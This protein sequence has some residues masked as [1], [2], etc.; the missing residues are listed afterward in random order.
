MTT[1]GGFVTGLACGAA[2]G[3]VAALLFAPRQGAELRARMG[4]SMNQIGRRAKDLSDR[5]TEKM[6]GMAERASDAVHDTADRAA[7]IASR[8]N[9]MSGTPIRPS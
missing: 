9:D 5:T 6:S 3:G 2:L 4:E 7:D 8:A 1:G